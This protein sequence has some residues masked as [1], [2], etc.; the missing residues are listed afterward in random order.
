MIDDRDY[1]GYGAGPPDPQRP[2]GARMTGRPC[3]IKGLVKFLD[4]VTARDR[5]WIRTARE[6][7]EHWR[8]VHPG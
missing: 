4:H 2:G 1:I 8:R 5:V 7:A 6:I 3:R